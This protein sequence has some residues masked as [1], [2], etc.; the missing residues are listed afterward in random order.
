MAE[1]YQRSW[2]TPMEGRQ[3]HTTVLIK[4]T[5]TA[6]RGREMVESKLVRI[7]EMAR[8]MPEIRFAS[9]YHYLNEELLL[10]C[11][12]VLDVRKP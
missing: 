11:H 12:R 10:E 8:T 3:P 7:A 1:K 5:L 9:L 4:D 6:H 2:V